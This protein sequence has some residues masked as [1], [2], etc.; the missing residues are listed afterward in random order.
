MKVM[1]A[2]GDQAIS[3]LSN[4]KWYVHSVFEHTFNLT[5]K[6]QHRLILITSLSSQQVVPGGIYLS[7]VEFRQLKSHIYVGQV[8]VLQGSTID[9]LIE[10]RHWYL[11]V[12]D[13][14][15]SQIKIVNLNTQRVSNLYE[16]AKTINKV[17]GFGYNF[18]EF[19]KKSTF[20]FK[21]Q[22][23]WLLND[24]TLK[25]GINFF[26]GR[27]VGLTPAGDDFLL[28]WLL[29]S[30]LKKSDAKLSKIIQNKII[31]PLYTTDISRNYLYWGI[32]GY[33]SSALLA[34][35]DYLNGQE[36]HLE[37]EQI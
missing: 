10:N 7:P 34:L 15:K 29:I 28:G 24:A 31:S 13:Q 36:S 14:Y 25:K 35:I 32:N 20:P 1:Q 23:N 27:G 3:T 17:T 9:V 30:Q 16:T 4:G 6:E 5:D 8:M 33:F 26:I 21:T 37:L 11:V 18:T 19:L 22:T 12:S 2:F